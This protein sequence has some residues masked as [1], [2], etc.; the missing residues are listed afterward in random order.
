MGLDKYI[1]KGVW[2]FS[3]VNSNDFLLFHKFEQFPFIL[4]LASRYP[5]R[6][7]DACSFLTEEGCFS[8]CC[9]DAAEYRS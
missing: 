5:A 4:H 7:L 6:V 2:N 9:A 8:I 3:T 1:S